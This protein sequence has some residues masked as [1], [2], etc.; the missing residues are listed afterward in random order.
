[1]VEKER[2]GEA[3][4]RG[5]VKRLTRMFQ[6][7]GVYADRFERLFVE[8]TRS[9]YRAEGTRFAST[10][11]CGEYLEHCERRLDEEQRL[12]LIHI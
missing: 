11:E 3:V 9:F 5:K 1:M 8:A 6:S 4:D 12:S 7:L 10:G 2:N